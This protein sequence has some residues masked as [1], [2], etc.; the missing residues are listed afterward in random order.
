[1]NYQMAIYAAQ[2]LLCDMRGNPQPV[3]S[4]IVRKMRGGSQAQKRLKLR[5][6]SGC[7]SRAAMRAYGMLGQFI[8]RTPEAIA[9]A[10]AKLRRLNG[11]VNR[12]W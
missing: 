1:M 5:D 4:R 7:Y 11:P 9:N 6:G 3:K 8:P 12:V 10:M 2:V